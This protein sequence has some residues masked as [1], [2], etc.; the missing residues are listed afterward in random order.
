MTELFYYRIRTPSTIALGTK[1]LGE[2]RVTRQSHLC[3]FGA[4]AELP[5]QSVFPVDSSG[6]TVYMEDWEIATLLQ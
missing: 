1:Y 3:V 6:E 2:R 4:T 5:Y